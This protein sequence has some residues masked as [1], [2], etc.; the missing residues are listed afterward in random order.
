MLIGYIETDGNR[1][2]VR[3][4]GKM[5]HGR[6]RI[7]LRY[8]E[9]ELIQGLQKVMETEDFAFLLSIMGE[10]K[11]ILEQRCGSI[12]RRVDTICVPAVCPIFIK[13]FGMNLIVSYNLTQE[14]ISKSAG[15]ETS[16]NGTLLIHT[17]W[18]DKQRTKSYEFHRG[19]RGIAVIDGIAYEAMANY[20]GK[21]VVL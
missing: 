18:L 19:D 6:E 12:N 8:S 15:T 14:S 3:T 7:L 20:E 17:M 2:E 4:H 10:S 5:D 16:V 21:V 13:G 9:R 1:I 11:K